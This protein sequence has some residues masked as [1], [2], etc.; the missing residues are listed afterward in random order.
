M[1]TNQDGDKRCDLTTILS[2]NESFDVV[3]FSHALDDHVKGA[4]DFFWFDYAKAYQGDNRAT[5]K[6]LWFSSAFVLDSNVCEDARVI[7]QEA[8]H[9]LKEG[10]G[11]KVFAEPDSLNQWIEDNGLVKEDVDDSIIHAGTLLKNVD[12]DLVLEVVSF[13]PRATAPLEARQQPESI[14]VDT[15]NSQELSDILG[16]ICG[17]VIILP[18]EWNP[19]R[20]AYFEPNTYSAIKY[21]FE[22][23]F[24][25]ILYE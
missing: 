14:T 17:F 21:V 5:I 20:N 13:F 19:A 4:K 9:R 16:L 12:H 25:G 1:H 23:N 24:F 7:R 3:V 22:C 2:S 15:R 11:I 18:K 10:Y 8:R 6:E